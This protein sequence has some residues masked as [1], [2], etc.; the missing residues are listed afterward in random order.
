MPR[1]VK[2]ALNIYANPRAPAGFSTARK[3]LKAIDKQNTK[4]R[5]KPTNKRLAA[6]EAWLQT[7]ESYTIHRPVRKNFPRNPYIVTNVMD[8]WEA[9]LMD[10]QNTNKHNDGVK[11]LLSVIDVFLSFYI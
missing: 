9:D 3:L 7:Q 11:Y 6:V 8:M 4:A 1:T 5:S 2:T 10:V